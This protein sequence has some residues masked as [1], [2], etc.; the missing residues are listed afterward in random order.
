MRR[1]RSPWPDPL[2]PAAL[3]G[4]PAPGPL[5]LRQRTAQHQ[6]PVHDTVA[7]FLLRG[8]RLL[9][10]D[11]RIAADVGELPHDIEPEQ[12]AF[13]LHGLLPLILASAPPFTG[14]VKAISELL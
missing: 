11:L 4:A 13:E 6:G 10:N 12:L 1:S 5:L 7:R 2:S 3:A 8:R 14:E 9:I